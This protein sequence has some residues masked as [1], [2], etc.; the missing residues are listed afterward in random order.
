MAIATLVSQETNLAGTLVTSLSSSDG[1]GSTFTVRFFDTKTKAARTPQSTTL[2]FIINKDNSRAERIMAS[3]HSTASG[4]TTIT[5]A[6]NGRTIPLFG[7]GAGTTTG[8][9]HRPGDSIGCV[10]NHEGVEQI[11][12]IMDGTNGTSG[13]AFRVGDET[14]VDIFFYAQN[15][16]A[17]KPYFAYDSGTSGWIYSDDGSSSTPFGTG[18]GV[19]GGNGITVTAGVI[20]CD[21]TDTNVFNATP[22]A[23]VVPVADGSNKL[24]NDWLNDGPP[25]PIGSLLL[26]TTD[27]AP[28]NYLLCDGSAV[29]RSTYATLFA[30]ISTTYGVGDGSTTFNLPDLRGR[31]PLGQD[32]MGGASANVVTHAN[33]D[34]LGGTEG[35]ETH[36]L[37]TAELPAHTHTVSVHAGDTLHGGTGAGMESGG[38]TATS[39]TGSDTAHENM[40]PYITLNYIIRYA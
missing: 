14:D 13:T 35:S 27:T 9:N 7:I 26:W 1:D 38:S 4:I 25:V 30:V 3:S 18:A 23:S 11:N 6:T 16:D 8:N 22:A 2:D 24:D 12:N 33:A 39:S 17:N 20:A 5:I 37:V 28:A 10:S 19:S 32:D 31:L 15:A 21:L 34:T 29:S 40:P 36:T